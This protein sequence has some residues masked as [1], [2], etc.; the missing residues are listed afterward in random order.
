MTRKYLVL[1]LMGVIA[2]ALVTLAGSGT[3]VQANHLT[4]ADNFAVDADITGNTANAL[5]ARESCVEVAAGGSTQVDIVV[6]NLPVAIPLSSGFAYSLLYDNP[7]IAVTAFDHSNFLIAFNAGSSALDATQEV[8][9]D[10]DGK[11]DA[12][13]IDI[14]DF[15]ANLDAAETGSGVLGRLTISVDAAAANGS[16]PLHLFEAAQIDQFNTTHPP[17][18]ALSAQIAVGVACNSLLAPEPPP[19]IMGD[20]DCTN[21]VNA[22]DALKLL[23]FGAALS[24]AQT[25]PCYDIGFLTPHVGDVDCSGAVNAVD[26]LKVLRHNAGLSVA[27]TEPCDDIGT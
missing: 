24:V 7:E 16:Y 27:Q 26:A 22:V 13:A 23:R 1:G 15:S 19:G 12:A 17:K 11:F 2:L 25:E 14:A 6:N 10:T 21:S 18:D 9:P 3:G 5:G 4:G 8:M 20:V